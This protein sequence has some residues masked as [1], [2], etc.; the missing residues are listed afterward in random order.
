MK[1]YKIFFLLLFI[2]SIVFSQNKKFTIEDVILN[3]YYKLAPEYLSQLKWAEGTDYL[4]Y[5]KDQKL[6]KLNP[7]TGDTLK[8]LTLTD[9]KKSLTKIDTSVNLKRFPTITWINEHS[10][11]YDKDSLNLI[12]LLN[13]QETKI[14]FEFPNRAENIKIAPSNNSAA[15]TLGNNL[16]YITNKNKVKQITNE[17]DA[18]IVS[19]QAIARYE[20]G[21]KKGIF[22][23]PNSNY[24]AFYQKDERG[25][26]DYPLVEIDSIP[27]KL[28]NIKYPMAGQTS[29][30][31]KVGVFDTKNNK[32][33]WLKTE[34]EKEQYL[35]NVTWDPNEKYI[36]VVHL[37][38]D[39]NHLRLIKYDAAS[40]EIV[41][42]LFEETDKE[43][44]E[45]E[46][47]LQ[48]ICP[49]QD[50][51]IWFSE[52]SGFNHLY[53]YNTNGNLIKQIT[54]GDWIVKS[55]AGFNKE[56]KELFIIATKDSPIEDHLYKVELTNNKIIR[57]TKPGFSHR[58]S[59]NPKNNLF[60]DIYSSIETPTV[61]QIIDAEGKVIHKIL[62]SKNPLKGY[63][64]SKPIIKKIT[65]K[66]GV[67][68][69]TRTIL[70]TEF[71]STKKYPAIFYVY[72]GP[73]AQLID[74]SW[75]F[76]RY[77]FW[78]QYM[79][80]RGFII[81]TIDNRG[82]DNR[83]L[84][85]EQ[86]TFRKL[87]TIEIEDQLLG[88]NYLSKFNYVDT[89]RVGVFGWSYGGFMTISLM[90]RTNNAFKVGVA[91]GAVIDWKTYEIMYTERYMDTP[92]NNPDGYQKAN[93]LNYV[94][95]LKDKL[96]LVHGTS[97][98]TVVWQ[99]TLAFA[100]KAA[101]LDKDLDYFP[102]V[103][104]GHGVSGYDAIHLYRKVSNYFI[105]NL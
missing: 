88:L 24:I 27:A 21:I 70:P 93:L 28:K 100:K 11:S 50:K 5:A 91:G 73:H 86:A 89:N 84:E 18:G 34:G 42:T 66:A 71:D 82:S 13:N 99:N 12:Y 10:I 58:V 17:E 103:G 14:N 55:I 80:Q 49:D 35:T 45:P 41:K 74:N 44:V 79:A 81:F 78:F 37:N 46:H 33:T 30:I 96:L 22:W 67:E 61:T 64:I 51:F 57:L 2:S 102:Y 29:E 105:D 54:S 77:D 47:Q 15:F 7:V 72:G 3:S 48:F 76:G 87:G 69:Y 90:L 104:H 6:L 98:P 83:G 20:F 68:F 39:Q 32:I 60:L 19:G 59:Y 85:F 92:K 31:A 4:S 52:R 23:S 65:N 75:Y 38:R 9:L 8:V 40:G 97:D 36:Y 95:N 63:E 101:N 26:T 25:I 43:Y 56:T 94:E 53:L 62:E 1:N 16:Y